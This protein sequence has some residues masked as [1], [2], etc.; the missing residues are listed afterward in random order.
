M[1]VEKIENIDKFFDAYCKYKNIDKVIG[2]IGVIGGEPLLEKN[3]EVLEKIGGTWSNKPIEITTN[4][5][6][7]L[8]N[9]SFFLDNDINAKV[10]IDGTK[11]MHYARRKSKEKDAY[12]K[13][14][15][16][17]EFLINNH[18]NTTIMTV[19]NPEY[20]TE[21]IKYLDLL[22]GK[23]WLKNKYLNV[24]FIPEVNSGND[25]IQ[26][27]YLIK[28]LELIEDLVK[29]DD[30]MRFIDKR[31]MIPGLINFQK[32]LLLA[33][34][35]KFYPYRCANIN[36]PDFTFLPNGEVYICLGLLDSRT[37]VGKFYPNIEIYDYNIKNLEK[38]KINYNKKCKECI[39]K[40]FCMGGCPGTAINYTNNVLGC[41]CKLWENPL[42]LDYIKYIV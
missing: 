41:Y 17:I 14:W 18:I 13:T 34:E 9:K 19:F 35:G 7:I 10:S 6:Y 26:L 40:V 32:N 33:R 1:T 31:K 30:R 42:F 5:T 4:G 36:N 37:C 23:G 15:S 27:N 24:A 20:G 22:E 12:E 39:M 2:S 8:E 29:K 3:G 11:D 16:G 21:Y 28:S 25:D 38:R